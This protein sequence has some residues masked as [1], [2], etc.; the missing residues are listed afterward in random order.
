MSL[1]FTTLVPMKLLIHILIPTDLLV[2]VNPVAHDPSIY[3]PGIHKENICKAHIGTCDSVLVKKK[4]VVRS[5][6]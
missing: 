2:H 1:V 3:K 4:M 5:A 6:H